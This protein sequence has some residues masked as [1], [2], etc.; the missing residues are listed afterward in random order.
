MRS[1]RYSDEGD[2]DI[3][4]RSMDFIVAAV[5]ACARHLARTERINRA[6]HRRDTIRV[7]SLGPQSSRAAGANSAIFVTVNWVELGGVQKST[8]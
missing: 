5:P 6:T 7:W 8:I 2:L 1:V 4:F 3:C